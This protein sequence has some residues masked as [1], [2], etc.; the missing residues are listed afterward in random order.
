M[1]SL[2]HKGKLETPLVTK[3][4]KKPRSR[5]ALTSARNTSVLT[6]SKPIIRSN[7]PL[8]RTNTQRSDKSISSLTAREKSLINQNLLLKRENEKYARL[9][10]KADDYIKDELAKCKAENVALKKFVLKTWEWVEG[11]LDNKAEEEVRAIVMA[12]NRIK[13]KISN[14]I[15][16]GKSQNEYKIPNAKQKDILQKKEEELANLKK[17]L[18][19]EQHINKSLAIYID[20]INTPNVQKET[21]TNKT[22][23]VDSNNLINDEADEEINDYP[24]GVSIPGFIKSLSLT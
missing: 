24:K 18:N 8:T 1:I 9:L 6:L 19:E 13:H 21:F 2:N 4:I 12:E 22:I 3:G 16:K 15:H 20:Y 10:K 7:T 11:K 23:A 17:R 14:L 5:N